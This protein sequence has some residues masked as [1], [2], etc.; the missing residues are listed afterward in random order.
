MSLEAE[1]AFRQLL[2]IET[3][4]ERTLLQT[5]TR[6]DNVAAQVLDLARVQYAR[7]VRELAEAAVVKDF[8]E[9]Y[10]NVY[11]SLISGC[12]ALLAAYGYRVQGGDGA[13]FETLRLAAIGL[14]ASDPETGNL[15][16]TIREPIRSARNEAEYQRPGVTTVAELRQLFEAAASI[17]PAIV[18]LVGRLAAASDLPL[19]EVWTVPET[20]E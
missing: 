2:A 14:T 17:L 4:K 13:H 12:K 7:G 9:P 10:L 3:S 5:L 11:R 19:S 8:D 15:L 6:G 20:P 18:R 1:D 16:E